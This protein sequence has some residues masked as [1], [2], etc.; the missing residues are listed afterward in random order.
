MVRGSFAAGEPRGTALVDRDGAR[1]RCRHGF[2]DAAIEVLEDDASRWLQFGTGTI[3]SLMDLQWTHRLVLPYTQAMTAC[4]LFQSNPRRIVFHGLGG[5]SLI[6][7]FRHHRPDAA[8]TAIEKEPRIIEIAREQFGVETGDEK[9]QVVEAD[10]CDVS[11]AEMPPADLIM[12]DLFDENGL[13][14]WL[15]KPEFYARAAATMSDRAILVAN[16][17]MRDDDEFFEVIGGMRQVFD[18]R[19]LV[20]PVNGYRNIIALAFAHVLEP[21]ELALVDLYHHARSLREELSIDYP[22]LLDDLRGANLVHEGALV[23]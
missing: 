8:L 11:P 12:V 20:L 19:L 5:G 3:Q 21:K 15:L 23:L 13:P 18:S 4:L 2:G 1:R 14:H 6:R 22:R 10:A 9:L 7:F 16:L 17:W